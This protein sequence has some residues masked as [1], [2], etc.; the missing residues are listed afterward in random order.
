MHLHSSASQYEGALG[1]I[2]NCETGTRVTGEDANQRIDMT[3]KWKTRG[4]EAVRVIC[5]DKPGEYP[6]VGYFVR[7]GGIHSW[8][9]DGINS[10]T[11]EGRFFNDPE[12]PSEND[13][14]PDED[15]V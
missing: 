8:T 2:I 7:H 6:V 13:L 4:G 9:A 15:Q 10:W 5:V 1:E 12:S 14:I 11:A 3:R